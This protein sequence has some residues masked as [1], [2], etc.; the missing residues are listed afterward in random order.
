MTFY[1]LVVQILLL[2]PPLHLAPE[3]ITGYEPS[4]L[5]AKVQGREDSMSQCVRGGV[6]FRCQF[7]F[8]A[9]EKRRLW[10]DNC[11]QVREVRS[12]LKYDPISETYRVSRDML[13]DADPPETGQFESLN[14]A[15]TSVLE[16]EGIP[17]SFVTG[18]NSSLQQSDRLYVDTRA[19]C[20]CRE[21]FSQALAKVTNVL[22]LG[23]IQLRPF[24]SGWRRIAIGQG[25][26]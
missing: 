5:S 4:G 12:T 19:I 15:F 22:T 6:E 20:Y 7:K 14:K 17:L 26:K 1:G 2:A 23:L 25:R 11:R 9:C 3:F 13:G 18:D 8:E 24:D 21:D 16:M 10:L